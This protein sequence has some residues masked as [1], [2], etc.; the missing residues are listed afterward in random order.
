MLV[1][2]PHARY[3]ATVSKDEASRL[4]AEAENGTSSHES[5]ASTPTPV[6]PDTSG[7]GSTAPSGQGGEQ[8]T[9][10]LSSHEVCSGSN[11]ARYSGLL[12]T[13]PTIAETRAFGYS[14][15][16]H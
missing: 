10:C 9:L 13:W 15:P 2:D 14:F 6:A 12:L 4:I 5:G 3:S 7:Y 8:Q 16:D 11:A 1:I